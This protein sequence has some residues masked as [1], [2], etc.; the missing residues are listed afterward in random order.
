MLVFVILKKLHLV[1]ILVVQY[2]NN[3]R[4]SLYFYLTFITFNFYLPIRIKRS[5][6]FSASLFDMKQAQ[7]YDNNFGWL[8]LIIDYFSFK[9]KQKINIVLWKTDL[10]LFQIQISLVNEKWISIFITNK[11]RNL[12]RVYFCSLFLQM[13]WIIK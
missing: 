2:N 3:Y 8:L 13:Y 10:S 7:F 12:F 4:V 6:T 1:F 11:V 5:S 9:L